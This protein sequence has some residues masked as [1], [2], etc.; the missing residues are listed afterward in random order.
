MQID[1]SA[2]SAILQLF[3]LLGGV[4]TVWK[5]AVFLTSLREELNRVSEQ[6]TQHAD[7]VLELLDRHDGRIKDHEGRIV[8]NEAWQAV[9]DGVKAAVKAGAIAT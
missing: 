5:A 3:L 1:N 4:A 8:K 7:H 2:V 9:H 6:L